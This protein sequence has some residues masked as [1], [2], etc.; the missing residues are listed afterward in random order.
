MKAWRIGLAV[1]GVLGVCFGLVE[2]L[3]GAPP[4]SLLRVLV[5]LVAAVIIHDALWSPA[6]IGVGAALTRVPARGRRYLQGGLVVGA[7][8]TVIAVPMIYIRGQQP[9]SKAILLQH[10]GLNLLLLL[11][12][13]AAVTALAYGVRVLRDRKTAS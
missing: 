6:L 8:L 1:L 4:A 11:G 2:L 5:W 9:V 3:T 10:V 13:V 7:A 12:V